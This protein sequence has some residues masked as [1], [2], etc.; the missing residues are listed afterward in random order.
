MRRWPRAGAH[1]TGC[2]LATSGSPAISAP[3]I[4]DRRLCDP[5]LRRV[6]PCHD[7]P[8][9]TPTT[10]FCAMECAY[11][12]TAQPRQCPTK[13][14]VDPRRGAVATEFTKS[15]RLSALHDC[16][17]GL[18]RPR[19]HLITDREATAR[20]DIRQPVDASEIRDKPLVFLTCELSFVLGGDSRRDTPPKRRR[21]ATET[22]PGRCWPPDR[23]IGVHRILGRPKRVRHRADRAEERPHGT[24]FRLGAGS[25]SPPRPAWPP[26]GDFR[27]PMGARSAA[28]VPNTVEIEPT[29][30]RPYTLR[31]LGFGG[32]LAQR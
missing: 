9:P 16:S 28:C 3:S 10:G 15:I 17:G 5:A 14:M 20:F 2:S 21:S 13:I 24:D 8:A 11:P 23:R 6:C 29:G 22:H 7:D 1:E 25:L 32:R 18:D 27:H 31:R 30:G 26:R 4:G 19:F 12:P